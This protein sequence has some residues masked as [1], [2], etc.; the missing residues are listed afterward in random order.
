MNVSFPSLFETLTLCTVISPVV[1]LEPA[2]GD[3][4]EA[5]GD[6]ELTLEL[7]SLPLDPLPTP[8]PE[9]LPYWA[10]TPAAN[11]REHASVVIECIF[12]LERYY[13]IRKASSALVINERCR[14]ELE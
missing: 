11:R 1:G 9:S 13:G 4:T 7:E 12:G 3:A 10:I 5:G 6:A 14:S 8:Y 2:A